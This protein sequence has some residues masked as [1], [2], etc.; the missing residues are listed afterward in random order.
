[1]LKAYKVAD[2]IIHLSMPDDHFLWPFL[3][4]YMPFETVPACNPLIE[5]E[6]VDA[7][8]ELEMNPLYI[9]DSKEEGQ[10]KIDLYSSPE[11]FCIEMFPTMVS[12]IAGRCQISS[13][14]RAGRMLILGN[15]PENA[16]FAIDNALMLMLAFSTAPLM[17][18]EMHS[19]VISYQGKGYLFLG[20][21]GTGKSTHSH[22]WLKNLEGAEL[23]NDDNPIIRVCD[24]GI[25]RV[26]GS[27]WSG[28]TAC[29]RNVSAP[30]GAV[31]RIRR[32]PYNKATRMNVLEAYT[33]IFSSCSGFK[34]DNRMTDAQHKTIEAVITNVPCYVMECL[35]DDDAA[36][37]CASAVANMQDNG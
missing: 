16:A 1:M 18:L 28:K 27:P 26:F 32:A 25:V 5:L 21:S 10:P 8:P 3:T 37:V 19:S 15:G 14:Y 7:L 13:D 29:Y 9:A 2:H 12:P 23:I 36:R 33:S 34:S 31:V 17:T 6:V 11:G 20:R 4:N 24:D 30:I 35:P 22:L